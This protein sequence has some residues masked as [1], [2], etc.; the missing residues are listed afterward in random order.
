[1][2]LSHLTGI[3]RTH[4]RTMREI[5]PEA[6]PGRQLEDCSVPELFQLGMI[7]YTERAVHE[8]RLPSGYISDGSS[9]HEW[10]YGKVRVRVGLHPGKVLDGGGFSSA[11]QRRLFEDVIDAMGA[12]MLRHARKA[13]DA[14]AHLPIEFPLVADGHRPVSEE[15]R[16]M[17]DELL[18]STLEQANIPVRVIGGSPVDRLERLVEVF[19]LPTVM[20]VSH[21]L[22]LARADMT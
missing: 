16:T 7:R 10:V 14:F 2:A 5:L 19:G 20:P 17:C 3:P 15:F 6:L 22:E 8:S 13:Y 9:L 1:M 18:L 21:A 11:E 4:A 12:V